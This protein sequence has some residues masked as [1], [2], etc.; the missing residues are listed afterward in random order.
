MVIATQIIRNYDFYSIGGSTCSGKSTIAQMLIDKYAW[1]SY[2]ADDFLPQHLEKSSSEIHPTLHKLSK[3]TWNEIWMR[4]LHEQIEDVFQG[5]HEESL[6][7]MEDLL[8]LKEV[9]KTNL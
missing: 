6:M 7:I 5:Y 8:G 4:P 1:N 3:L 2:K 9:L